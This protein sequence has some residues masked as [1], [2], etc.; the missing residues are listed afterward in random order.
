MFFT[1]LASEQYPTLR[2]SRSI[3][4]VDSSSYVMFDFSKLHLCDKQAAAAYQRLSCSSSDVDFEQETSYQI[5]SKNHQ[6]SIKVV[7]HSRKL[8][9]KIHQ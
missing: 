5:I 2:T 7:Q 9:N 6:D 3:D 1:H 8:D 4:I